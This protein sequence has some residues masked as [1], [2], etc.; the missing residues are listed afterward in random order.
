MLHGPAFFLNWN[1][2]GMGGLSTKRYC[3]IS[4]TPSLR[5]GPTSVPKTVK[6]VDK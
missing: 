5:G 2:F 6:L 1:H 4:S 3:F